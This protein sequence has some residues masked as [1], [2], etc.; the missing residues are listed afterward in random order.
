MNKDYY[1]ILG[2]SRTATQEEIKK[3]YRRLALKYHP[4]RNPGDPQAEE[5]FKEITEAYQVLSDPA[6]RASYDRYGRVET[7]GGGAGGWGF[8]GFSGF[9]DIFE[10]FFGDIFGTRETRSRAQRG[11]DILHR[12]TI[13]LSDALK[14]TTLNL[15]VKRMETCPQC[16]GLGAVNP[17]DYATCPTCEG[18]GQIYYRQGFFTVSRTCPHCG[19]EGIILKNP[20]SR[21]K[22]EGRIT[23]ERTVRVEIP[24]GMEDGFRIRMPGEG[25]AGVYGGEPGDLYVEVKIKEDPLF[26]REGRHL[27]YEPRIS[28]VQAILGTRLEIPLMDEVIEV[29]VP[30]GLQPGDTIKVKGKGMP[31]LDG[32]R[33]GDLLVRPR[34]SIPKDLSPRE[35]ELLE[36]IAS[37]RQE[38][39]SPHGGKGFFSRVREK[40]IS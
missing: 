9:S 19:G 35:R 30:P 39:V 2:V 36:E 22:G 40:L 34:V 21:C 12:V 16:K 18:R 15:K 29:N 25:H 17:G 28:Y 26:R 38:K 1:S 33:R 4:D 32:G 11:K 24:P 14:G 6:K 23:V 31:S 5:R 3:A 7:G 27:I 37:L 8:E 20:C 13:T 10:E